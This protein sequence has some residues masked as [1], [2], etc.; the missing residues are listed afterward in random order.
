MLSEWTVAR[1]VIP[2]AVLGEAF[3]PSFKTYQAVKR[4]LPIVRQL[5]LVVPLGGRQ[6]Y[7]VQLLYEPDLAMTKLSIEGTHCVTGGYF[8]LGHAPHLLSGCRNLQQFSVDSI[9]LAWRDLTL[10]PSLKKLSISFKR[11]KDHD[12]VVFAADFNPD[13]AAPSFR[14]LSRILHSC[15]SLTSLTLTGCFHY[16]RGGPVVG[17]QQHTIRLNHLKSLTLGGDGPSIDALCRVLEVP[18]MTFLSIATSAWRTIHSLPSLALQLNTTV[19][20]SQL[21]PYISVGLL[22]VHANVYPIFIDFAE[23]DSGIIRARLEASELNAPWSDS[24][25]FDILTRM[26]FNDM[27]ELVVIDHS[28]RHRGR[29][30]APSTVEEWE[31]VAKVL[32]RIRRCTVYDGVGW[33]DGLLEMLCTKDVFTWVEL[34]AMAFNLPL[35]ATES[36]REAFGQGIGKLTLRPNNSLSL[37]FNGLP[38]TFDIISDLTRSH[39]DSS[40][41]NHIQW[42]P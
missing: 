1:A 20:I 42:S 22:P 33:S 2:Y 13:M 37:Q 6:A 39:S 16:S 7:W 29:R 17:F 41:R 35:D 27:E 25:W 24:S 40:S 30:P 8:R 32:P 38:A 21:R 28:S 4:G 34:T 11:F 5:R 26:P 9:G 36:D 19:P 15:S 18:A 12:D 14:D 3:R 31:A 10:P 23:A